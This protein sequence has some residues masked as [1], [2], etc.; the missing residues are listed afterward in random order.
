MQMFTTKN[1]NIFTLI[2]S[3]LSKLSAEY[4]SRQINKGNNGDY[5][6]HN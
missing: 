5:H 4:E 6:I 1:A 2:T 3:N